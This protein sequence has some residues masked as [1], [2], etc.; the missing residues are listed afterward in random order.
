MANLR[1]SNG[2]SAS[3]N[4]IVEMDSGRVVQL[5]T[6]MRVDRRRLKDIIQGWEMAHAALNGGLSRGGRVDAFMGG[7]DEIEPEVLR[8]MFHLAAI[9]RK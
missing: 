1:P 6:D 4:R 9:V 3:R 2:N 8:K 5:P 7:R